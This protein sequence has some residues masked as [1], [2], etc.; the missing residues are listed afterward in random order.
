[1]KMR[2]RRCSRVANGCDNIALFHGLP[3]GEQERRAMGVLHFN[4]VRV[5]YH[6][7][8]SV[9]AVKRGGRDRACDTRM[10]FRTLRQG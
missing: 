4:A 1:M 9:G 7:I 8:V 5:L 6:D 2:R 10:D 3:C